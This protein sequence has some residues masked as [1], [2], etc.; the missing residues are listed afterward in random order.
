MNV[1]LNLE[2]VQLQDREQFLDMAI[3]HF[4]ELNPAFV[5]HDDW[6]HSYFENIQ[7]HADCFLCWI[8]A[9]SRR[10]GFVLFGLEDHR[11]LP[12]KNGVIWELYVVPSERRKGFARSAAQL[13]VEQL[14]G[15]SPSKIHLEV[16]VGNRPAEALWRSL[17]FEKVTERFVLQFKKSE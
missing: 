14:T 10:V 11:F 7:S 5:P 15:L 13:A 8:A 4:S 9:D 16:M 6:Q 12:R 17:G 3:Q 1:P 2:P